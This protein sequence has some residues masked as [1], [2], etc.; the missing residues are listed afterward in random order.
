MRTRRNTFVV[1][2]EANDTEVDVNVVAAAPM[3]TQFV[4]SRLPCIRYEHF[5][6]AVAMTCAVKLLHGA[7]KLIVLPFT[8]PV[9]TDD[10]EREE[11]P[12]AIYAPFSRSILSFSVN[13]WPIS[14]LRAS[15]GTTIPSRDSATG[16]IHTL[17]M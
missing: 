11:R 6:V 1:E 17:S 8:I 2:A 9:D 13:H 5:V 3:F 12:P 15:A 10:S 4:P 14:E 16:G 7:R